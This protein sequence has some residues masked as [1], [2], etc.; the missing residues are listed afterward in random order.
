MHL[1]SQAL[2]QPHNLLR[3]HTLL[4]GAMVVASAI[5]ASQ[6]HAQSG[7]YLGGNVGQSHYK[8]QSPLTAPIDSA[9][10]GFKAYGGYQLTTGVAIEA[11]YADLG[12]FQAG[13]NS[14]KASGGFMDLVTTVPIA[15][16]LSALARG[17]AFDNRSTLINQGQSRLEKGLMLKVGAGVQYELSPNTAL[18]GEW[19]RYG[20]RVNSQTANTDLYS[21]GVVVKF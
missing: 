5:G 14:L 10:S 4:A 1:A 21:L 19:E 20:A 9:N 7:F 8:E 11:G 13:V 16:Q 3:V 17:G 12:T 2:P 18:R 15:P 6:A